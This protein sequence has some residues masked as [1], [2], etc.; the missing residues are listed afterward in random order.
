M[1]PSVHACP[2]PWAREPRRGQ[3]VVIELARR[4]AAI[5]ATIRGHARRAPCAPGRDARAARRRARARPAPHARH[6]GGAPVLARRAG[7]SRSSATAC[8]CW[9][10]APRRGVE[11]LGRSGQDV[12]ARYPEVTRAL[13]DRPVDAFLIDGEI[14]AFDGDG[15]PSFQRLQARMGL[16][17]VADVERGMRD[18]ARHGVFFDC[19]A[20]DG[21]DLR[22]RPLTARK[23]CLARP[24]ARRRR[25]ALRGPRGRATARHFSRRHRDARL[26]GIVAK[27]GASRYAGGRSRDWIKIK[28]QLRQEFVIGGYTDPQGSRGHFGA[29]H[30]GVYERPVER[31]RLVYVGKVGT[32]FD[33]KTLRAILARLA[34]LGAETPRR[35]TWERRGRPRPPLGGAARWSARCASPS[36][37][38]RA[39]SG[40]RPSSGSGRRQARPH[41]CAEGSRARPTASGAGA[42][43]GD[44]TERWLRAAAR[45]RS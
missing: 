3:S 11:L 1:L 19:L 22:E 6:R 12:T 5:R 25:G 28:C 24:A 29:L 43:T 13:L 39:G 27:R 23:A 35:S 4:F 32:G 10:L 41:E 9:R 18:G 37:P 20:A 44:G 8:A 15:R 17:V 45:G 2:T 38:T 34:P 16:T 14:V 42:A 7:S 30:L 31:P 26:E 40:I 36:G 33:D 21:R